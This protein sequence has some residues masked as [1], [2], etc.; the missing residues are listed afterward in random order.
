M[1]SFTSPDVR[2]GVSINGGVLSTDDQ[3]PANTA[4]IAVIDGPTQVQV[5]EQIQLNGDRSSDQ[6]TKDNTL[7]QYRWRVVSSP[8]AVD[9]FDA[10]THLPFFFPSAPGLYSIELI[11]SDD[12]LDSA[13]A[14]I[15]IAVAAAPNQPPV[16]VGNWPDEADVGDEVV[17]NAT[18]SDADGD[19]PIFYDWVQVSGP[20]SITLAVT[21][22]GLDLVGRFTPM[23]AGTYRFE[24][25]PNDGKEDGQP[26]SM[27]IEVFEVLNVG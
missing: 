14:Q 22:N 5:G 21:A 18:L 23:T 25:R 8:A 7:L 11:V 2:F 19:S 6:E 4:P 15:D 1:D 27:T 9:L 17:L 20:E 24:L 13:P 3:P 12:Q 26:L 10:Q 16:A